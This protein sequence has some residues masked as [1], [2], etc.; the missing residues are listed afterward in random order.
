MGNTS[1]RQKR[2]KPKPKRRKTEPKTILTPQKLK[3]SQEEIFLSSYLKSHWFL[4]FRDDSIEVKTLISHASNTIRIFKIGA[5]SKIKFHSKHQI[6]FEERSGE[7]MAIEFNEKTKKFIIIKKPSEGG[8]SA[9]SVELKDPSPPII[10]AEKI[11][12][13]A[14]RLYYGPLS[15]IQF[16]NIFRHMFSMRY[17]FLFEK[18]QFENVGILAKLDRPPKH[19]FNE[20]PKKSKISIFFKFFTENYKKIYQRETEDLSP[21]DKAVVDHVRFESNYKIYSYHREYEKESERHSAML[22]ITSKVV[23]V[24]HF[25]Y[26]NRKVMKSA[27]LS[28]E[29]F[30]KRLSCEGVSE[31]DGWETCFLRRKKYCLNSDTLYLF[32]S[33][34]FPLTDRFLERPKKSYRVEIAGFFKAPNQ[35][36]YCVKEASLNGFFKS[37]DRS[38]IASVQNWQDKIEIVLN[39]F[40]SGSKREMGFDKKMY[41]ELAKL[42]NLKTFKKA[43][44]DLGFLVDAR[45]HYVIDLKRKR[46]LD[47]RRDSLFPGNFSVFR[48]I[49]SDYLLAAN[50][51]EMFLEIY[52]IRGDVLRPVKDLHLQRLSC[53][54]IEYLLKVF[55]LVIFRSGE[56]VI[57]MKVQLLDEEDGVLRRQSDLCLVHLRP[58]LSFKTLKIVDLEFSFVLRRIFFKHNIWHLQSITRHN[59]IVSIKLYDMRFDNQIG[60]AQFR[61]TSGPAFSSVLI[62]N[63]LFVYTPAIEN[64]EKDCV[65]FSYRI[66]QK[67]H[68][69]KPLRS[70]VIYKGRSFWE[71]VDLHQDGFF[72]IFGCLRERELAKHA[73]RLAR[74]PKND[75]FL[76]EPRNTFLY[77]INDNLDV[78]KLLPLVPYRLQSLVRHFGVVSSWKILSS[79]FA[80]F[81]C[82]SNKNDTEIKTF[83]INI[84]SGKVSEV[85][86][87]S[88]VGVSQK[89]LEIVVGSMD[90][91]IFRDKIFSEDFYHLKL[92]NQ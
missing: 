59:T 3:F 75:G 39:D 17:A 19:T 21:Q 49:G 6:D 15:S 14:E 18:S 92:F 36:S 72:L 51:E 30:R 57:P 42:T 16:L 52:Q 74:L 81:T 70:L 46:V 78:L 61:S 84:S 62:G 69:M 37:F 7:T 67:R 12:E 26:R 91:V 53:Y 4:D 60:R 54:R 48:S 58:D 77:V 63:R 80:L 85:R 23:C 71:A 89:S 47:W 76:Y 27:Y 35:R 33:F 8:F 45:Y 64:P 24:K 9:Y 56:V 68:K 10:R 41:P 1:K 22:L 40:T 88:G 5:D 28:I 83:I 79:K 82:F 32:C 66:N 2:V 38:T 86:S 31:I 13:A 34:G 11:F 55:E 73:P 29:E 90:G 44:P 25:G 20:I 65:L 43:G 87:G 50:E